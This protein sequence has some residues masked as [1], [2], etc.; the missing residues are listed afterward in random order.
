MAKP[1]ARMARDQLAL[2]TIRASI[3][4][5]VQARMTKLGQA[6]RRRFDPSDDGSVGVKVDKGGN[7]VLDPKSFGG[8]PVPII[9]VANSAEGTVS[10]NRHL[11]RWPKSGATTPIPAATPTRRAP[12]SD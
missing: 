8:T 3:R 12:Q 6:P 9:W 1:I 2:A 5:A 11:H 7:I 10:N 4:P